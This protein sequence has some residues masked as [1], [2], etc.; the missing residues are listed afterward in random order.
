MND[1]PIHNAFPD[2]REQARLARFDRDQR[3]ERGERN[4]ERADRERTRPWLEQDRPDLRRRVWREWRDRQWALVELRERL[5]P[6]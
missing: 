2:R 5:P 3:R 4:R 6:D 1:Q